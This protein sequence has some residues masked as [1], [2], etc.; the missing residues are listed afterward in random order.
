MNKHG[1]VGL[2]DEDNTE[3]VSKTNDT[4]SRTM[5]TAMMGL[6]SGSMHLLDDLL[7]NNKPAVNK[8][9]T[10][11][12]IDKKSLAEVKRM[13]KRLKNIKDLKR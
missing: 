4:R 5:L 10:T 1:L 7:P 6:A 3:L 13:R 2:M 12:D 8:E 9:I 11:E